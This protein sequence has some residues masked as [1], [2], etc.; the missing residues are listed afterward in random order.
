ME[1]FDITLGV[2]RSFEIANIGRITFTKWSSNKAEIALADNSIYQ[3]VPRGIWGVQYDVV[4][5]GQPL[6]QSKMSFWG[7]ITITPIKEAHH[8]FTLKHKG[9]K[10]G[11][12]LQN[13]KG[14]EIARIIQN[15]T[16]KSF[17]STYTL[18]TQPGFTQ[19]EQGKLLVLL[20]GYHYRAMQSAAMSTGAVAGQ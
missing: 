4:K 12:V 7:K 2:T 9:Y 3:M 20:L 5:D 13:Y 17:K 18:S 6:Y 16:W 11:Y 1:Q 8:F 10:G 15:F 19:A 14:E